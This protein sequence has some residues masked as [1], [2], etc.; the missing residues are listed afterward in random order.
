M[1]VTGFNIMSNFFSLNSKEEEE[2][3]DDFWTFDDWDND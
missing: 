3:D 1:S 2:E